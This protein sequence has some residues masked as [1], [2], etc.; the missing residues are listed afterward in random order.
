MKVTVKNPL[1]DLLRFFLHVR[2][3]RRR[4][5]RAPAVAL[6]PGRMNELSALLHPPVQELTVLAR[7]E[8]SPTS[9]TFRM[10]PADGNATVAA[11]RAG[12]YIALEVETGG[13]RVSRPFSIASPPDESLHGN[14]YD[15]TVRSAADG[16]VAPWILEHWKSGTE[17]CASD[18]QG[19]FSWEPLRDSRSV[20]C[21]AG[22]S[23]ITPFRSLIPDLLEHQPDANIVL[24][25]GIVSP[26]EAIFNAQWEELSNRYA[27]RF[28]YVPVCS[29]AEAGWSGEAGFLT[30]ELI[31]RVVEQPG[32]AS[33][34]VC[35]PAAMHAFLDA[36]LEKFGLR[37]GQVRRENFGGAR[38]DGAASGSFT[39]TVEVEG[40]DQVVSVAA[41]PRE[42]VL[43]ALER[44]GL[45]PPALCRSG[46]CGWC[47][48]RLLTGSI[49][50][51]ERSDGR[52]AADRKFGYF[53]PCSSWP[54]SDV[55]IRVPR[56][57]KQ[58][59][60]RNI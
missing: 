9:A 21:L 56:N 60:G 57:P 33:C 22:G 24:L 2:T 55:T 51:P 18:P 36:E 31:S 4:F 44:A 39:I 46:E 42:T 48:S 10:A 7:T 14:Y 52:R 28:R 30:A 58:R 54:E 20:V 13:V 25:Y 1:V 49:S 3:R 40:A 47:R 50:V 59:K 6:A 38:H 11:F 15:I 41:D 16:F 23:G 37:P 27:D 32:D 45:N 43:T 12:Q 29:G 8:E 35:G 34:F 17:V 19:F 5:R 26:E 53:H